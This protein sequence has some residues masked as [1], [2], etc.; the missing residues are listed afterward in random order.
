VKRKT[1]IGFGKLTKKEVS[2]INKN[3]VM[4]AFFLFFPL[5]SGIL[6]P[7]ENRLKTSSDTPLNS[8]ILCFKKILS[9]KII[10]QNLLLSSI[11]KG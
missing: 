8:L 3:V 1:G 9:G 11:Q 10:F 5:F 2:L 7:W 6:N 4:F